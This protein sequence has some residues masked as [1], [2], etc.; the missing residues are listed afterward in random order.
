[1]LGGGMEKI[2]TNFTN[3]G[4]MEFKTPKPRLFTP[5]NTQRRAC[6]PLFFLIQG[7][8][9][10]FLLRC[11]KNFSIR[12]LKV[13]LMAELESPN[14][15]KQICRDIGQEELTADTESFVPL[16]ETS[17]YIFLLDFI[18]NNNGKCGGPV[19]G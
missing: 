6:L 7:Y 4:V 2:I 5:G 14:T 3:L 15:L 12:F 13:R 17:L 1:M 11:P 10:Q 9:V 8:D 18:M 19:S 16:K